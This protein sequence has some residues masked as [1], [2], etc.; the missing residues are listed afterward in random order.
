MKNRA[1]QGS[2]LVEAV[3]CLPVVLVLVLGCMQIAHI[4]MA[5]Q[6]VQY[7]AFAAAR[8]LLTVPNSRHFTAVQPGGDAHKAAAAV[9]AWIALSQRPGA[10][11]VRVPGWG[12]I[13]GSGGIDEKL[14]LELK[15]PA[16]EW[17]PVVTVNFDFPMVIPVAGPIIG[18]AVNPWQ[19]NQEWLERKADVTGNTHGGESVRYP[20]IRFR[21]SAALSKPY[22]L[23]DFTGD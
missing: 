4:W 9:C 22:I 2:M 11:P 10:T 7:A 20:Y 8:S 1:E 13:P 15:Q 21:E 23:P 3:I 14:R 19:E 6:V 12:G 16:G 18:W 5:R 17:V